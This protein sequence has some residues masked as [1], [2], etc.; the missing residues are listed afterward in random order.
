MKTN[1]HLWL[2]RGLA[3]ACLAMAFQVMASGLESQ[4]PIP[5]VA[6]VTP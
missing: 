3:V 4:G 6:V 1:R 5:P 2:I